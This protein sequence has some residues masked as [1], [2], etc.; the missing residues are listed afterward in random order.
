MTIYRQIVL[1]IIGLLAAVFLATMATT[2]ENS[3][4]YLQEQ[5][6]SHAQDAASSLAISVSRFIKS[7]DIPA[8]VS[9]T[10]AM[11]DGGYYRHI[12]VTDMQGA[13]IVDRVSDVT[14]EGVPSWFVELVPL[15]T[16]VTE[17]TIMD[18]WNQAGLIRVTSHPGYAYRQL[19]N[20]L[21]MGAV[22]FAVGA[23]VIIFVGILILK[24]TFRPLAE[25]ERQA[26]AIARKEFPL[27]PDIPK[28]RELASIVTAMNKLTGTVK[29]MLDEADASISHLRSIAFQSPVTGLPNRQRFMGI[30]GEKIGSE[31]EF[32]TALLCLVELCRFKD[33]NNRKGYVEGDR[34][35]KEAGRLLQSSL[36]PEPKAVVAH[37]SGA[38]F[39]V[40]TEEFQDAEELGNRLTSTLCRLRETGITDVD[41]VAHVGITAYDGAQNTTQLLSDADTAL[42]SAQSSDANTWAFHSGTR[43]A[44]PAR[45]ATEW[46]DLIESALDSNRLRLVFQPVVGITN[47][48][49]LHREALVRMAQTGEDGMESLLNAAAFMPMAVSLGLTKDI[50]RH[51]IEVVVTHIEGAGAQ[52]G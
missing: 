47:G 35:L 41:D 10:D 23:L 15:E 11:F 24:I 9:T 40:L 21:S 25:V 45:T 5:L 22:W 32:S 51:V 46:R 20:S 13:I 36:P 50:D 3:R 30:L 34:L 16:P 8:V 26:E 12:T 44:I 2:V 39:A 29:R 37:L 1:L 7:G 49:V 38:T 17:A 14:L 33:F 27:V 19:W 6:H 42:R 4:A 18:G 52:G 28:T 43:D 31:E 48:A